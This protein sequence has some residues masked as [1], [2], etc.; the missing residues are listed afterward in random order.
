MDSFIYIDRCR[1]FECVYEIKD[2]NEVTWEEVK[3]QRADKGSEFLEVWD[4][5]LLVG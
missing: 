2:E 5:R 3:R 1:D 4:E